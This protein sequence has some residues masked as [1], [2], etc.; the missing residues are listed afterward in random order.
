MPKV[1]SCTYIHVSNRKSMKFK[2][3]P[4]KGGAHIYFPTPETHPKMGAHTYSAWLCP[5]IKSDSESN[6]ILSLSMVHHYRVSRAKWCTAWC[7]KGRKKDRKEMTRLRHHHTPNTVVPKK[8]GPNLVGNVVRI[9]WVQR[10]Y[11]V[12]PFRGECEWRWL[13][14][15]R[16]AAYSRGGR[17]PEQYRQ[18]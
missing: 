13:L 14:I 8:D 6:T 16:R 11:I 7:E 5:G 4:T 1:S 10:S 3:N 18:R 12:A 2:Q 9:P 17:E 15:F